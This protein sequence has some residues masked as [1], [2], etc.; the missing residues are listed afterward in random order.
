MT[1]IKLAIFWLSYLYFPAVVLIGWFLLRRSGR[2]SD[3]GSKALAV[4]F[5]ATISLAAW[6]RFVE[7]RLL[8]VN[9]HDIKLCTADAPGQL[10]AVV[11]ADTHLGLFG[12]AMPMQRIVERVNDLDPDLVLIPGDFTY[13]PTQRQMAT[14]FAP[15]ARLEAPT[16]AV[17]GNHDEGIPGPDLTDPLI[18]RLEGYGVEVLD[19]GERVFESEKGS[20]LA[21]VGARDHWAMVRDGEAV[22]A[23]K[24][25]KTG[26]PV[27]YLQHNPD[28]IEEARNIGHFD[29]MVAGHTHG[30][31]INLPIITCAF[32]FACDVQRYGLLQHERGQL[33]VTSGTGMVSLPFRFNVPPVIDVLELSL[34]DCGA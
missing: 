30:G 23:W 17:M 32:T 25:Q 18:A 10:R 14:L 2:F 4:L 29:L 11:F 27:I 15:L 28:F 34:E 33:F 9:S 13:Y 7:P 20:R 31:Q 3:R 19:P 8:T 16:F 1:L 6:A 24:A 22:D 5:L 21:I 26:Y 12:N